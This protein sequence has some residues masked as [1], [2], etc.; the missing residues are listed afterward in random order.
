M[1]KKKVEKKAPAVEYKYRNQRYTKGQAIR[2]KCIDCSGG[3]LAEVRECTVD[4]PLYH[5]RMGTDPMRAIDRESE[6]YRKKVEALKK[7]R[8]AKAEKKLAHK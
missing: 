7:A 6:A 4:C 2:A 1:A 5:F 3:S 8:I